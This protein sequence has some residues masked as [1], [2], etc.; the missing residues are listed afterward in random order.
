[1]CPNRWW[2]ASCLRHV[3]RVGLSFCFA[4]L[5]ASTASSEIIS[6]AG[7]NTWQWNGF[8]RRS[9][10]KTISAA[11]TW[12]TVTLLGGDSSSQDLRSLLLEAESDPPTA[13]VSGFVFL[14]KNANGLMEIT[15]WAV[16]DIKLALSVTGDPTPIRITYSK[17]DGSYS[18]TGLLPGTYTISIITSCPAPA[19]SGVQRKL[20]DQF[21]TPVVVGTGVVA[22]DNLSISDIQLEAGYKGVNYNFAQL[23]WPIDAF[24]KRLLINGGHEHTVPEPGVWFMLAPA[25]AAPALS[26][27]RRR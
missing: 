12:S 6:L 7:F 14:D 19:T 26:S 4:L 2:S 1:M 5:F 8:S 20:L 17:P 16:L 3:Q 22:A 23:S 10:S 18:F 13:S 21:N 9:S 27:R 11:N 24:S 15:D 25:L